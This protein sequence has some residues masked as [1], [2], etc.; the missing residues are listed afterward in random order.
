MKQELRVEQKQIITPQLLL[1]LKILILPNFEL[2]TLI[3]TELEQNPALEITTETSEQS[4]KELET[5]EDS[6]IDSQIA[7]SNEEFNITDY[8]NDDNAY[9]AETESIFELP[10]NTIRATL[11]IEEKL[12]AQIKQY[13]DEADFKIAEYIVGNLND[14]GFLPMPIEDIAIKFNA[15]TLHIQDI[16]NVIQ[17]IEPGGIGSKNLQEALLIQL[18]IL[19]YSEDNL[20]LK[21]IKN[22]FDQFLNRQILYLSKALNTSVENIAHAMNN[23]KNLEPRP[24]RRYLSDTASYINPDFAIVWQGDNLTAMINDETFPVLRISARYRDILRHPKNFTNEEVGFARTKLQNALN[25]I[26][27]IESRKK[28]LNQIINYI[29]INQKEFLINGKEFIKP[30]PIKTIAEALQVH[31]STISRACQGKYVETPVGI[32]SLKYFFTTGIGEY[33]RNSLK[34]K[35]RNLIAQ[36]NKNRP[37]TDDE[38]ANILAQ[39]NIKLS[40]RTVAKYREELKIASSTERIQK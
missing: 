28:L 21:I 10:E 27:A 19:G 23:L 6:N 12:T 7:P 35:I 37:Y 25:L 5:P 2:E 16:I 24:I 8:I 29:I 22:Y 9:P 11:S 1:N 39:Q 14:E 4:D 20:E 15:S 17:H 32:F 30:I 33:S 18:Q 34:E 26:R 38:I 31:I 13:L 3:R 40:R 36:E